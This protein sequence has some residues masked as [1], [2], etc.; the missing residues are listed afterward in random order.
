MKRAR[1]F[2]YTKQMI[3]GE[4]IANKHAERIKCVL[5]ANLC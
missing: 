4:R 3:V 5:Y 1:R 2:I